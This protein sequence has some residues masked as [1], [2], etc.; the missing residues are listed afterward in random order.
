MC[1]VKMA[2]MKV[3]RPGFGCSSVDFHCTKNSF[4]LLAKHKN[5]HHGNFF[6]DSYSPL[7]SSD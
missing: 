7:F 2:V 6:N 5:T 1:I 4:A 3:G